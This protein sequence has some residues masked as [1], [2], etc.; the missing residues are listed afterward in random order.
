MPSTFCNVALAVPL[1][2][3]FTYGVPEELRAQAQPGCRVLV[4]FRKKAMVGVVTA[5]DVEPPKDT[6]IHDV[7]KVLDEL[8]PALPPKL[9]ELGD[10]IAGYYVAPVGEVFRAMLPPNTELLLRREIALT[11]AGRKLAEGLQHGTTL[12]D[13]LLTDVE[14]LQKLAQKKGAMQ[15]GASAAK[16]VDPGV[17][18]RLQK[19]G[20]IE[21]RESVQGRKRKMQ[22][23]V[24]W[25]GSA[26]GT[27]TLNE[28]QELIRALL[29]TERGP[30][31]VARLIKL[32]Q[33]SRAIV[34]RMLRQGLLEG[35][36]EPI[37]PAEDPFDT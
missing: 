13:L 21:L 27:A 1:R 6:T 22:Q 8:H 32:A 25:K 24:A 35:W 2:T 33:V 9:L 17:A 30:L 16:I 18:Q 12:T 23:V 28:K 20:L 37:D 15:I 14:F 29:D 11:D 31:P 10:W 36:E 19:R 34:E 5:V 4:P 3:T 7:R 26:D